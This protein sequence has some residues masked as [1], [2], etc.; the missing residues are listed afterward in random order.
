M[1][2]FNKIA[3]QNTFLVDEASNLKDSGFISNNDYNRIKK[4]NPPLKSNRNILLRFGFF[5]L[6]SFLFGSIMGL[7]AWF[8]IGMGNDSNNSIVTLFALYSIVGIFVCEFLSKEHFGYGI[9]DAFILGTIGSICG[10]VI[11]LITLLNQTDDY[12]YSSFDQYQILIYFIMSIAGLIACLR[13]CHWI[14]ALVSCIGLVGTFYYLISKYP[15]G[16]K[17]MP[18]LMMLLAAGLFF[19]YTKLSKTNKIYHYSNSL[20]VL[21]VFS[22]VLFY[23]SGNYLV[24]RTLSETLLGNVVSEGQDIPF[25]ILFW[26]ITFG[27][28]AFYLYWSIVKKDKV[29]LN[30]GF[31]TFCFSIFTFR[32]FHSVL[33]AEIALTLAGILIFTVTYFIIKKIKNNE[34]GVTFKPDRNNNSTN[35]VN[36]EAAIINS[37]VN[38]SPQDEGPMKFDGGGFSGGG[39]GD[40]F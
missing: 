26:I 15:I 30:I 6:G 19:L 31:I 38:V 14:S 25:A 37:Q 34:S 32:T 36:L 12:Y 8:I 16:L 21:K 3:L 39:A 18:F 1:I 23:F 5:L 22:L 9:D 2:A 28:P 17:L 24:V 35:L 7:M 40:S 13:Y 11:N 4:E 27:V 29:F 20:V 10:F 33:P